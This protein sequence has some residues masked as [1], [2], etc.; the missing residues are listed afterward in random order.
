LFSEPPERENAEAH[1]HFKFQE[2]FRMKW[3]HLFSLSAVV[4]GCALLLPPSAWSR[5]VN[6]QP[7]DSN[8]N[9]AA[10][11]E[12]ATMV[13]AEAHLL[14]ALD[15]RKTQAGAE[16]DAVLDGRVDLQGGT[17]LPRGT[18]L[19]GT[20][21]AD[22]MHSG[23]TSRLALRF[24]EAKLKDGKSIPIH[25]MISGIS[26]PEYDTGYTGS[27]DV[28]GPM[29]WDRRTLQIDDV[30]V[31]SHVDLHSQVASQDSGVLVSTQRDDVKLG[32]GSRIALAI[33]AQNASTSGGA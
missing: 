13:P 20:V 18:T 33:G 29:N 25:A 10:A 19:V 5:G 8:S 16:F 30:G 7:E 27:S 12:A 9:S 4:A 11:Q 2:S 24:T 14:R 31:L 28:Q 17:T 3:G 26:G 21:V 23:G 22:E 15:A 6:D 1:I 32:A